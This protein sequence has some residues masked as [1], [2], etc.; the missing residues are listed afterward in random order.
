MYRPTQE[1]T[2]K[3]SRFRTAVLGH[4]DHDAASLQVFNIVPGSRHN[5]YRYTRLQIVALHII[6]C[7]GKYLPQVGGS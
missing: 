7:T 3:N 1:S 5:P 6:T 4:L 2:N